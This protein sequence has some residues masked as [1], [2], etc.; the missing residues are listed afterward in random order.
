M[1]FA[2]HLFSLKDRDSIHST[3]QNNIRK[4]LNI[5]KNGLL[6]RGIA[7]TEN[8]QFVSVHERRHSDDVTLLRLSVNHGLDRLSNEFL[9]R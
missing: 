5:N 8:T 2:N 1:K 9:L 4:E 3:C 7:A 6:V